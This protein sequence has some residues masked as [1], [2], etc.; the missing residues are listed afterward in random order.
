[1][2]LPYH[3]VEE[4]YSISYLKVWGDIQKPHNGMTFLLVWVDDT[5]EAGSYGMALVWMHDGGGPR[6]SVHLDL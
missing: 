6:D 3:T 5:S 2:E 1:M 4:L